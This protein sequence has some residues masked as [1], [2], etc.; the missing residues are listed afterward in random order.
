LTAVQAVAWILLSGAALRSRLTKD[1]AS[2]VVMRNNRRNGYYAFAV[3]SLLALV[4][5][6]FPLAIAVV[7]TMLWAYWLVL[8]LRME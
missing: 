5:F 3:Y 7:T 4:A 8:G 2:A 1:E 6:W